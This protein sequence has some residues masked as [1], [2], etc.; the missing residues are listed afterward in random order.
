MKGEMNRYNLLFEE[1]ETRQLLS[2][3]ASIVAAPIFRGIANQ[4]DSLI[5]II[6]S[7]VTALRV[8]NEE[9]A[10]AMSQRVREGV[11][12]AVEKLTPVSIDVALARIADDPLALVSAFQSPK[13][14]RSS[15]EADLPDIDSLAS[16]FPRLSQIIADRD[17]RT[18]IAEAVRSALQDAFS[19][20]RSRAIDGLREFL[21]RSEMSSVLLLTGKA[22]NVALTNDGHVTIQEHPPQIRSD[23]L[24]HLTGP[25]TTV[26]H[27]SEKLNAMQQWL[28]PEAH[29]TPEISPAIPLRIA[30]QAIVADRNVAGG[31]NPEQCSTM[32]QQYGHV[33]IDYWKREIS[34]TP[35]ENVVRALIELHVSLGE[36]LGDFANLSG[37]TEFEFDSLIQADGL[38]TDIRARCVGGLTILATATF[39][40]VHVKRSRLRGNQLANEMHIVEMDDS[41]DID[42]FDKT[43]RYE[44]PRHE[45]WALS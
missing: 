2:A 24:E 8:V 16:R 42:A 23:R 22:T 17:D 6:N 3:D 9:A 19:V 28:G 15:F 18:F 7:P 37:I 12:E 27:V 34:S 29:E 43:V 38:I 45:S 32:P 25:T 4:G 41:K 5:A 30:E 39:I 11:V 35:A 26:N 31:D 13:E 21:P 36:P 44:M 33:S 20:V 14:L 1:L 10:E 40:V